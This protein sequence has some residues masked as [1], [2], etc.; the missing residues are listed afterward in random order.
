MV[1]FTTGN[2]WAI[3]RDAKDPDAA[4][5]F[6]KFMCAENTWLL[7]ANATRDYQKKHNRPYIPT[8]TGDKIADQLQIERLYEPIDPKFDDAVKFF[9]QLLQ[10]SQPVPTSTSPVANQLNDDLQNVGVKP[11]L[12]GEKSAKDTLDQAN[13][14]AQQDIDAFKG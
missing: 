5:E 10:Q 2:V 3:T 13:Q 7:G 8:L 6:I 4:W 12:N 14:K 1:S 11:A 9:P